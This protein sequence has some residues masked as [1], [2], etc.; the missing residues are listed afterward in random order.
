MIRTITKSLLSGLV[1]GRT[2]LSVAL[3]S[4]VGSL[5]SKLSEFVVAVGSTSIAAGSC[6]AILRGRLP[7]AGGRRPG[8]GGTGRDR[9]RVAS[10]GGS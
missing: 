5:S 9:G 1:T 10:L 4:G 8:P 3:R 2:V 6:G 7:A